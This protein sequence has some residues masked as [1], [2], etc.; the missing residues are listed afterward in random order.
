[1]EKLSYFGLDERAIEAESIRIR[2]SEIETLDRLEASLTWRFDK[3][4]RFFAEFR[5]VL[6]QNL[7]KTAERVIEGEILALG[8]A[9]KKPPP[10]AA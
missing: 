4:V 3:A 8:T 9:A 7:R 2:A 5:G 10:A 1:L 6:G